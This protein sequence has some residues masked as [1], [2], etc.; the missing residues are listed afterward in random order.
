MLVRSVQTHPRLEPL[1]LKALNKYALRRGKISK[2]D[3]NLLADAV[4]SAVDVPGQI[5]A[6]LNA[7]HVRVVDLFKQLDDDDSGTVDAREF[8]K[9]MYGPAPRPSPAP[10]QHH[11]AHAR[12]TPS[13]SPT[14]HPHPPLTLSSRSPQPS[15]G[16]Y[17]LGL[18]ASEEAIDAVFASFDANSDGSIAYE[19][20]HQL[21]VRSVQA[22]HRRP[23]AGPPPPRL[24]SAHVRCAIV[25]DRRSIPSSH[26]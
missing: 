21:L 5:R 3:S 16:R 6:A 12:P 22:R 23:H 13:P 2:E 8:M 15:S 7:R 11:E 18:D 1:P 4:T 9:A 17:E 26:R 10:T 25:R 14:P 24:C 20:M 19:E